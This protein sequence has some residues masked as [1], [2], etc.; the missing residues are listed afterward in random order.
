MKVLA[1]YIDPNDCKNKNTIPYPSGFFQIKREIK[2]NERGKTDLQMN[3]LSLINE[4]L[5]FKTSGKSPIILE[6]SM[7]YTSN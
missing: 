5:K 6:E 3:R 7:E 4:K 2:S 1:W